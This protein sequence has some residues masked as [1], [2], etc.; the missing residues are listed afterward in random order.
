MKKVIIFG[1]TGNLGKEIAKEL[2]KQGYDLTVVV[3]NEAKGKSLSDI[4]SKYIVADVFHLSNHENILDK[5]DIIISALGKSV[6]P[7]D[8]SKPTFKEVDY[9]ANEGILNLATKAGVKKFIYVSAF[10]SEKYLHLEYFKVHHDFSELLKQSGIDY[11]IIKPPAIFSAFIDMIE[12][13][14]KGQLVHIGKGDKKTNPIYEGDLAKI[15]VDAIHKQNSVIE[16]GGKNIYTR[17]ELNEIVQKGIDNKKSIKTVPLGLIKMALP[18]IKL[19]SKNM[20]DKFAFYIEVMQHDT[21]APQ[22]GMMSF[23]EYIK[24]KV[25]G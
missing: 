15:T 5:Q 18:M 19:F 4:T 1:A 10:H 11:S 2:V 17:K 22:L 3:R 7:N 12:M 6:S 8:Q 20:Y 24:M 13:A 25:N 21:I 16:A 14:K 9:T 23:E